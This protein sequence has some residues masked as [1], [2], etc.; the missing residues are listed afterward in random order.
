[1]SEAQR[2]MKKSDTRWVAFV[3]TL[4]LL[5][6]LETFFLLKPQLLLDL[7]FGP[8]AKETRDQPAG[9]VEKAG[10]NVRKQIKESLVWRDVSRD[11]LLFENDR[12]MTADQGNAEISLTDGGGIVMGPNTLVQ[13]ETISKGP[14]DPI[15]IRIDRGIFRRIRGLDQRPIELSIGG[16]KVTT[17][18]DAEFSARVIESTKG[19]PTTEIEMTQGAASIRAGDGPETKLISGQRTTVS[20]QQIAAPE[21]M[22]FIPI[23]PQA[24]TVIFSSSNERAEVTFE[25][26]GAPLGATPGRP[27]RLEVADAEKS[28]ARVSEKLIPGTIA[29]RESTRATLEI[30]LSNANRFGCKRIYLQI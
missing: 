27:V 13:I 14:T 15:R 7:I 9:K 8:P 28:Y 11:D 19:V 29:K 25:W 16:T 4:C 21:A 22:A 30:L 10:E 17:S 24:F 26:K 6:A 2:S 12:I 5:F 3:A 1:M 18:V 23:T 20:N